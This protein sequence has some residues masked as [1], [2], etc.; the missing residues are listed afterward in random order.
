MQACTHIFSNVLNQLLN[1]TTTHL[2]I[3]EQTLLINIPPKTVQNLSNYDIHLILIL[4]AAIMS[5][6]N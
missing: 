1:T 6:T 4:Y 2:T 5:A 3:L